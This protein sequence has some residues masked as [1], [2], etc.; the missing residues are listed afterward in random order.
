[1]PI[2]RRAIEVGSGTALGLTPTELRTV[3][4]VPEKL[5]FAMV[6]PGEVLLVRKVMTKAPL[7]TG[8][9]VIATVFAGVPSVSVRGVIPVTAR[10]PPTMGSTGGL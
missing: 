8:A 7:A 9:K 3:V 4:A 1:M 2:P 6:N 10:L 5:K